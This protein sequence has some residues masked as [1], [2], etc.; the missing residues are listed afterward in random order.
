MIDKILSS[1]EAEIVLNAL[2]CYI[3]HQITF[4]N[5]NKKYLN[6]LIKSHYLESIDDSQKLLSDISNAYDIKLLPF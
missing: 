5:D 6:D 4:V 1:D 2:E 3:K